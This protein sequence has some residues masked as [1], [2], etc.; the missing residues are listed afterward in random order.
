M[1]R[2]SA[3]RL[4]VYCAN[5][6]EK[7][8]TSLPRHIVKLT[9]ECTTINV[10]VHDQVRKL[11]G[12]DAT[13]PLGRLFH[14]SVKSPEDGAYQ[15]SEGDICHIRLHDVKR[16]VSKGDSIAT[17][18]DLE[19]ITNRT[20]AIS[21]HSLFAPDPPGAHSIPVPGVLHWPWTERMSEAS[22]LRQLSRARAWIKATRRTTAP[23][24]ITK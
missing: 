24:L 8:G 21:C 23:R 2:K 5:I 10:S 9:V 22:H 14:L 1:A 19:T 11:L 7:V 17:R 18:V 13:A 3:N 4:K 12:K 16:L 20:C 15:P 6:E